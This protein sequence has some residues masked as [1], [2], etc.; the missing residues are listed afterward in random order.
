MCADRLEDLS[1][2][3]AAL[4]RR[5]SNLLVVAGPENGGRACRHLLGDPGAARRALFVPTTVGVADVRTRWHG[6]ETADRFG[7]VD[8]TGTRSPGVADDSGPSPDGVAA[9]VDDAPWYHAVEDPTNL[10]LVG[11]TIRDGLDRLADDAPEPGTVRLCIDSLDP[12][13]DVASAEAV[14]RL[15]HVITASVRHVDGMGHV[16][17]A[18]G[19]DHT[20]RSLLEPLFDA[21]VTVES[22]ADGIRERWRLHESGYE[23]GWLVV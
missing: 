9:R 4:K 13:F 5:G 6:P 20:H 18:D 17:I 2:R 11:E 15:V 10:A 8:V 1:G 3:L 21:T 19:L 16:H 14:F 23:T 12:F 7:I 22:S